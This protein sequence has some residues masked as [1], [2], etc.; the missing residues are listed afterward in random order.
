[1][2]IFSSL[3]RAYERAGRIQEGLTALA[4]TLTFVDKTDEHYHEPELHRLK[5]E[6]TLQLKVESQKSKVSNPQPPTSN[7]QAAVEQEAEEC[8]LKAINIARQQQAKS[9]E[10]RAVMSLVRLRQQQASEQRAG[11]K[12]QEA[13]NRK[14]GA[15]AK[16]DEARRMLSA[17]YN[18]FTEGFDTQDLKDAKALL[19]SLASGV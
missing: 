3:A 16:L 12:E 1:L 2:W 6:L 7:I 15:R 4:E 10:L 11:S 13:E 17:I 14:Q 19:D 8:F 5:G 9:L 18:W